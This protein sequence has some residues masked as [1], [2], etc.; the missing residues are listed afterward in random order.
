M[1]VIVK[2]Q[3]VFYDSFL[4]LPSNDCFKEWDFALR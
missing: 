3:E 2:V 4:F 1:D